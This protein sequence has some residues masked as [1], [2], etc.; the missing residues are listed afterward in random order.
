MRVGV[1]AVV[2]SYGGNLEVVDNGKT[3]FII[4]GQDPKEFAEKIITLIENK[5]LYEEFS[6]N[7]IKKFNECFTASV[8]T[9]NTE[10]FYSKILG[11]VI[12]EN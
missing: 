5:S 2:S 11:G 1:P 8:M 6:K 10:K 3:G 4:N 12:D 9:K 7:S